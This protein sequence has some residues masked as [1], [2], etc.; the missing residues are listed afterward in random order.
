VIDLQTPQIFFNGKTAIFRRHSLC[1]TDDVYANVITFKSKLVLFANFKQGIRSFSHA[2]G[3]QPKH[4]ETQQ[5]TGRSAQR[6][7]PPVFWFWKLD[8]LL[9]LTITCNSSKL[10]A[11]F[12]EISGLGSAFMT[13]GWFRIAH[14]C[15]KYSNQPPQR[16]RSRNNQQ[17]FENR[18]S[19]S[20]NSTHVGVNRRLASWT[21]TKLA[22]CQSQLT[23]TLDL[24]W[25]LLQQG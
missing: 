15:V 6:I 9:Q 7:L 22:A 25:E 23:T 12:R 5:V 1:G 16:R 18:K 24:S 20:R 3:G 10:A 4:G 21:S 14:I 11:S 2:E 19:S 13:L 17:I 8:L